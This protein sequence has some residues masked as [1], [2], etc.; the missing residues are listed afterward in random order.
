MKIDL[1]IGKKK[2]E[3]IL[4]DFDDL[5]MP[6]TQN[7][8]DI[9]YGHVHD[10]RKSRNDILDSRNMGAMTDWQREAALKGDHW[11][12]QHDRDMYLEQ[13]AS[14]SLSG[15]GGSSDFVSHSEQPIQNAVYGGGVEFFQETHQG[16]HQSLGAEGALLPE[17]INVP[18]GLMCSVGMLAEHLN[19]ILTARSFS[20]G[21]GQHQQ[22]SQSDGADHAPKQQTQDGA[23]NNQE[24]HGQQENSPFAPPQNQHTMWELRRSTSPFVAMLKS[25]IQN[26]LSVFGIGGGRYRGS[27]G[28]LG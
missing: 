17:G 5:E 11:M 26:I 10:D 24:H 7:N 19:G 6:M 21:G 4:S 1:G 8:P 25:V 23:A 3:G 27:R 16:G 20:G 22:Q 9:A 18:Q 28:E 15:G 12:P 14:T 2:K 13:A